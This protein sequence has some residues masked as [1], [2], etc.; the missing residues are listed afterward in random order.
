LRLE[1]NILHIKDIRFSNKTA[2]RNGVLQV[3]RSE[4]QE[5]LQEDKRLRQ[6]DIELAHPGES[7]RILQV[8][9]VVEPRAKTE[10]GSVDFPGALG[11][12]GTVGQGRTCVLRG[13]AVVMSDC[14]GE[15]E[16]FM[17][18]P[19]GEIVDMQGPA[20]DLGIYGKTHNVVVLPYPADGVSLQDYRIALKVAGLKTAVYLAS[21]GKGLQPDQT[22]IY[23][24]PPL[25]D[26]DRMLD[27]LPRV[28]YIYQVLSQQFEIIPGDPVLYG[29]N[30]DKTL[31]SIIHPNEIL[32]G[33]LTRP[34]MS[35]LMET[36]LIQN[37]PIIKELYRRHG[38]ELYFAGVIITVAH[39]IE[40]EYERTAILAANMAKWTI[41]ADGVVLTKTGGGIPELTMALTAQRC[42][43]LGVRTAI[44]MMHFGADSTDI[45]FQGSTIFSMPEVDAIV[46]MG[47]PFMK[48]TLPPVERV[49]GKPVISPDLPPIDGEIV[50]DPRQ[51]KGTASQ[52]GNSK[53]KAVRC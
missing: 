26:K 35:F 1:L 15:C 30:I 49:I 2:I 33:G 34:Y 43:Q 7:C 14:S 53:L 36:Y 28:A 47:V 25:S 45:K 8:Y 24:L 29:R 42:E 32:D 23:E 13:A 10:D 4:L 31:P 21:A 37:H 38:K 17:G 6:V 12:Q 48:L 50:R 20:A 40:A 9:D 3:N 41:G 39:I 16:L 11:K 44:A 22:E 51:I 18:D 46:S 52:I 19:N 27:G 5:L